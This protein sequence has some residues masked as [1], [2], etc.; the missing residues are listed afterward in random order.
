MITDQNPKVF[1]HEPRA[2]SNEL[3]YQP[4]HTRAK[5]VVPATS[6]QLLWTSG[7]DSTFRLLQLVLE[8]RVPVQPIYLIDPDRRSMPIEIRSMRAIKQALTQIHPHTADLIFPT[9]YYSIADLDP[10]PE[11]D[12]AAARLRE[13]RKLGDQYPWFARFI[14]Q[15]NLHGIEIGIIHGDPTTSNFYLKDYFKPHSAINELDPAFSDILE[16][17][18]FKNLSFPIIHLSKVEMMEI[19]KQNGWFEFMELTWFCF[20]PLPG[21]KPCGQ[22][23]PCKIAK[24][25]GMGWRLPPEPEPL[26]LTITPKKTMLRRIYNRFKRK[27]DVFTGSE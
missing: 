22:C 24:N 3:P 11:I 12:A 27:F 2:T 7:W 1:P 16:Y 17:P 14:K 6:H 8:Q 23:S 15:F 9:F 21:E 4:Y 20:T 25:E 10:D 5:R 13:K 26:P 19:A 18:I